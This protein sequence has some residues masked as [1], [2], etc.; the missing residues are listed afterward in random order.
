MAEDQV[1]TQEQIDALQ[2]GKTGEEGDKEKSDEGEKSKKEAPQEV[3][4]EDKPEGEGTAAEPEAGM[5]TQ[6]ETVV[7]QPARFAPLQ[8]QPGEG[9]GK[10]GNIDL[11]LDVSVEVAVELGRTRMYIKD[12]LQLYPGSVV[13]LDKLAGEPVDLLVNDKLIAKGEVIVIDENFG[14]RVTDILDPAQ[15]IQSLK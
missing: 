12:I 2:K 6:E 13:G 9:M 15:R 7:V 4:L 14:V 11:I 10:P 5:K 1:L 3:G 8:L